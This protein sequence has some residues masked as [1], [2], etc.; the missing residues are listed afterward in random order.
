MLAKP[1]GLKLLVSTM[2]SL[3]SAWIESMKPPF[4]VRQPAL[5]RSATRFS[6]YAQSSAV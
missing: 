1:P 2:Q 3:P 6:A 4:S 5:P